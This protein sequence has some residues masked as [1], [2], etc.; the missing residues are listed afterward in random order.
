MLPN[1]GASHFAGAAV[2]PSN[3]VPV[4]SAGTVVTFFYVTMELA[5]PGKFLR[6]RHPTHVVVVNMAGSMG[7]SGTRRASV[8]AMLCR[9]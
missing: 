2:V 1:R 6:T 5:V 3:D 7:G 8:S 9:G 4:V